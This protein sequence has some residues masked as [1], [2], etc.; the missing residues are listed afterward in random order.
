VEALRLLLA[1][2]VEAPVAG[3]HVDLRL[4]AR[5][6]PELLARDLHDV[7]VELVDAKIVARAAPGGE[8][9]HAQADDA[10]AARPRAVV[11]ERARDA[12]ARPEVADRL[13]AQL[14]ID[15]LPAVV[16]HAV[17]EAAREARLL[18]AL[19]LAHA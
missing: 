10:D 3:H 13:H 6:V 5:Q 18:A 17:D 19:G 16:D 7:G 9:A 2:E 4:R 12:R 8:R 15:E 1:L 14:G 11:V